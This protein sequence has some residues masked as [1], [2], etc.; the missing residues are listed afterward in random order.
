[1]TSTAVLIHVGSS[2]SSVLVTAFHQGQ[3][4]LRHMYHL[5]LALDKN[6]A[7][8]FANFEIHVV[9]IQQ[10]VNPFIVNL[11]VGHSKSKIV[12]N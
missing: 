10:I 2:D 11:N 6:L 7:V 4:V 12:N 8:V 5:L 3:D 1:M 9:F